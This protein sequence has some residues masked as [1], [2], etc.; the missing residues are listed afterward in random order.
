VYDH[1]ICI[2]KLHQ[3]GNALPI[4]A[5]L[6]E[7]YL[8][9]TRMTVVWGFVGRPSPFDYGGFGRLDLHSLSRIFNISL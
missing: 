1:Q 8:K 3:M 6:G 2:C 5:I 7:L 9:M 4:V